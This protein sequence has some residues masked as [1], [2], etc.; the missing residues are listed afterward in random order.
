MLTGCVFSWLGCYWGLTRDVC[1]KM[2]EYMCYCRANARE[3]EWIFNTGRKRWICIPLSQ[4]VR[5]RTG[6]EEEHKRRTKR[7]WTH[8]WRNLRIT[9]YKKE[10]TPQETHLSNITMNWLWMRSVRFGNP[11]NPQ[12]NNSDHL[13]VKWCQLAPAFQ[14]VPGKDGKKQS[15]HLVSGFCESQG[16]N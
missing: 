9:W 16:R 7:R 14:N 10:K 6:V 2:V 12:H 1:T 15:S 13:C 3:N 8:W 11:I 4:D 5:R